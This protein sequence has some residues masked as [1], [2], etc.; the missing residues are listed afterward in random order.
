VRTGILHLDAEEEEMGK[1]GDVDGTDTAGS[2]EGSPVVFEV[3][4]E[5]SVPDVVRE[6]VLDLDG[7]AKTQRDL[8]V[9]A[10]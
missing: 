2:E 5:D 7:S 1:L 10:E 4:V 3:F 6:E 8:R 9:D